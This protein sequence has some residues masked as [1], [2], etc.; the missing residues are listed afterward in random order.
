MA[1]T[2]AAEGDRISYRSPS[3]LL[4]R[5]CV[6]ASQLHSLGSQFRWSASEVFLAASAKA[7]A[8]ALD[9]TLARPAAKVLAKTSA[10]AMARAMA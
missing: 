5:L 2:A 1:A 8:K 3:G 9:K 6:L 10:K 7:L 4:A